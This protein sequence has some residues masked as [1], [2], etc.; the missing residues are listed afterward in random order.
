MSSKNK[1]Y[2]ARRGRPLK[3]N[4]VK[5]VPVYRDEVDIR[6]LGRAALRLAM[7][8]DDTEQEL[9]EARKYDAGEDETNET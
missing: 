9:K 6:K 5:V 3:S 7:R 1:K 2:N 8:L 4:N